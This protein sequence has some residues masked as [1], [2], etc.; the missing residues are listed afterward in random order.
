MRNL[1]V[2]FLLA[3]GVSL[4]S[5]TQG[6]NSEDLLNDEVH[7]DDSNNESNQEELESQ[8]VDLQ[9]DNAVLTWELYYNKRFDF[10][11]GYPSNFLK[12]VGESGN[13]D[14]NTFENANGSSEMRASGIL[15]VLEETIEESFQSATKDGSYYEDERLITYKRQKDNWFVV[16]GKYYESIFYVKTVLEGDT[17]YT[18]YFE[19]HS[20]EEDKFQE[21]IKT[22]TKDFPGC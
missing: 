21:I 4:V 14:G 13:Q 6:V 1:S 15:N 3:I 19:Y 22:T 20:S 9:E 16:S 7:L 2:L 10:C 5:C 11:V 12:S 8:E 18:L 17:F